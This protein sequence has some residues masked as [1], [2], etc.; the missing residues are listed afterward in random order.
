GRRQALSQGPALVCGPEVVAGTGE[1]FTALWGTGYDKGRAFVEIE[2]RGKLLQSFWTDPAKTQ[3]SLKQPV[4]E[5]MRGGFNVRV[6][7]VRE[8]RG[9]LESRHVDVPWSNKDLT[10]K[11]EHFV[12]KLEPGKKET[13]TAVVSGPKAAQAAA[14]MV[15]TLYDA[16]LDAYLPHNWMHKFNVFRYDHSNLA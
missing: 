1:E 14:E 8:N 4:D 13:Y 12:N 3:V 5:G 7:Y 16:S 6:T 11:W 2:H 9:Y 15:A 10:V